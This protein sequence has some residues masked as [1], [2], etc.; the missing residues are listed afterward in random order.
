[1]IPVK[2]TAI[3]DFERNQQD[4]S[5]KDQGSGRRRLFI[6]VGLGIAVLMIFAII[7]LSSYAYQNDSSISPTPSAP[8]DAPQAEGKASDASSHPAPPVATKNSSQ[9]VPLLFN[10]HAILVIAIILV[11]LVNLS[12]ELNQPTREVIVDPE[13]HPTSSKVV[14]D[15][16]NQQHVEHTKNVESTPKS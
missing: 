7:A 11:L 10:K 13:L 16:I 6:K 15:T 2:P 14:A 12:I 1:M 9:T 4:T 3:T 5:A 8:L